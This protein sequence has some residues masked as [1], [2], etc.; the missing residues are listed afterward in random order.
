MAE[1]AVSAG[2]HEG[3]HHA[4]TFTDGRYP[5]TGFDN[6]THKFMAENITVMGTGDFPPV[7]VKVRAAD[8]GG[9]HTENNIIRRLNLRVWHGVH[10]DLM[11]AVISQSFH[12]RDPLNVLKGSGTAI[13]APDLARSVAVF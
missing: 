2:N 11:R 7:E 10:A 1:E 13:A 8:S 9:G 6:F 3:D 12:I 5:G 4:V